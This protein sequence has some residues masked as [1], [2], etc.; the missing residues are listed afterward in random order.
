MLIHGY[1]CLLTDSSEP[2]ILVIV[3]CLPKYTD[4]SR[5]LLEFLA[6]VSS[7]FYPIRERDIVTGIGNAFATT[8]Q[9]R[10]V[11]HV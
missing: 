5:T 2:G 6:L 8:V 4:I 11:K 3:N 10:V 9:K 1:I 7:S